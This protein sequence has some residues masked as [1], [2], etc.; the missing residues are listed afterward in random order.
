MV[1]V[2]DF[3]LISNV[4]HLLLLKGILEDLLLEQQILMQM[5]KK[6]VKFYIRSVTQGSH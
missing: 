5:F 2:F 3:Q 4:Q 1:N 6:F